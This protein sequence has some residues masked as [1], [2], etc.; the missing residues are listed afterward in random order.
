MTSPDR[1]RIL[2]AELA[3]LADTQRALQ[4]ELAAID[5]TTPHAAPAATEEIAV[6]T[7]VTA[8]SPDADKIT[9]FRRRFAG[10]AD[11]YPV[12]WENKK[13]AKS[14]YAP[15]C[16]NEWK[17]G[18]CGKPTIKCGECSVQSFFAVDDRV[19][20]RHLRGEI[21]AGVY[22]LLPDST[23]RFL[24]IDFDDATW[25]LDARAVLDA[26]RALAVPAALER[27]RSGAGGH[28]WIFFSGP[29]PA[30]RAR[31]L[32]NVLL[33][34]AMNHRPELSFASYDRMFPAQDTMPVGGFGNLIAL[35]FQNA[36]RER[37]HTIFV[38]DTLTPY[39]DQ[40]AF[41]AELATLS[42][43]DLER[44]V[45]PAEREGR[46]FGVPLP[47]AETHDVQPWL[48][49]ASREARHSPPKS[50][51]VLGPMPKTV[52]ITLGHGCY[53]DRTALPPGLVA[54]LV[55]LAAFQNPAFYKA[56][57]QRF[58]T[59]NI[60]RLISCAEF[61]RQHLTLPRGCL[62]EML[63]L[64]GAHG[65]A[66]QITDAREAGQR[67][68]LRFGGTLT[69]D[70][71]EAE[72]ALLPHDAGIL[73]ASTGW[74]KT[75][76][77]AS[78]IAARGVNTLVLVHRAELL[79]QW[80]DRLAMFL[81]RDADTIGVFGDKRHRLTGQ[82]D[83]ALIQSLVRKGVVKDV[84]DGYGHLIVD[85]C[86]HLSAASFE[87][88]ARRSNARYVLGLT[89]TV[90][91]RDGH[92]PIILMQCGPVRYRVNDREA[93]RRRT[94]DH[95]V[96]VRHTAFELPP[97]SGQERLPYASLEAC[98]VEANER[99]DQIVADVAAAVEGGRSPL[100]LTER[101]AH[102]DRLA[103]RLTVI[104]IPIIVLHGAMKPAARRAA[105]DALGR[106]DERPRVLVATGRYLG[107]GFDDARLDTL[108]MALP[109][110]WKGRVA[111]YVGRL[112]R[113]HEGK[114]DVIVYDYVDRRVPVLQRMAAER[115]RAYR[116]LGYTVADNL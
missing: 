100:V 87:Q 50:T 46:V 55:R 34:A 15:A 115:Q 74:G 20:R 91:R 30:A 43:V 5:A 38:D 106:T 63:A 56:L 31:A 19:L 78:M 92:E 2:R 90:A 54:Q 82:V 47:L 59:Y 61:E 71:R 73:A 33:T 72:A 76:L 42:R 39:V 16:A 8:A 84:L 26:A 93:A 22:P 11:V 53:I 48:A 9:L 60:P 83:V 81:G 104:G 1:A 75:V 114:A 10:R 12:R 17:P 7:R 6:Q 25:A 40:W 14:G 66:P 37:G 103:D 49:S 96:V 86:H 41:L 23:T 97:T 28:V 32:G 89:A 18:L 24:A 107:E 113:E 80:I 111:Q 62:D 29:V 85:E 68:A 102:L 3:A 99:T 52:G 67:I 70:Q 51:P 64:L 4:A 21:V 77:A 88:V 69:K 44:L 108:F 110:R 36:A 98:L 45:G 105:Y 35:P 94:F 95:R 27:S 116:A 79:R 112:H 109:I 65:I 58:S 101:R 57:A 13:T